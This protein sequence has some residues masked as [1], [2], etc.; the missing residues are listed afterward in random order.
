MKPLCNYLK[1]AGLTVGFLSVVMPVTAIQ[2]QDAS[3]TGS[4][5]TLEE[6][7][8]TARRREENLQNV[9]ASVQAF[10]SELLDAF[11]INDLAGITARVPG[12]NYA[13]P[14]ITDPQ[15]FMRGIGSDIQSAGADAPIGIFLNGVFMARNAGT[16]ID[17]YDLERVEVVKGPQS[18]RYGKNVVGG[19]INYVTKKPTDEFEASF[20]ATAGDYNR[21]DV[22]A[23]ARGPISEDVLFALSAVSRG[24]DPY[25]D[26]FLGDGEED[27]NRATLRG[28]LLLQVN[29]RLDITLAGDLTRLRGGS[30]W[31][32][33]AVTGDSS[34]VTYN[35]FFAP[36]I[37]GLPGF[38]LPDRN[39]PFV[40]G[41][42]RSGRKNFDGRNNA[43]M[44]DLNL[45][46]DYE[47]ASGLDLTSI[48][49]Y[50]DTETAT[51]SESCGLY[52]DFPL[53][54]ARGGLFIPD[55]TRIYG[56]SVYEYLAQ[57]PDCWF[58]QNKED[59]VSQTSQEFRL[60][61]GNTDHMEWSVGLF[62]MNE[63]I[64]RV[65]HVGFL[66]PD[67][68]VITEY[69]FSIAFGG[70]PV[71]E[72]LTQGV[73][74]AITQSDSENLG[75][76]GETTWHI[77][78]TL[79]LN[80]GLR[81]AR[82]SKKFTVTRFG[83]SFDAPIAGGGFTVSEK[84][85]WDAWLPSV[86]LSWTAAEDV[87]GYASYSRGYKPGGFFGENAG[88]PQAALVSFD[89]E[90]S[91]NFE[92]GL[93]SMLANRRVR[94]NGSVFYTDYT[95]LQTQ[96][97]V[98]IDPARPP[99]NFIANAKDGTTAY[100]LELDLEALLTENLMVFANYAYT[101]CEFNGEL[102]IDDEGTDIDG[103]TCRRTPKNGIN[104][105]ANWI[106][107]ISDNLQL[108]VGANYFWSDNFYFDNE[109]SD[110]LE[111][112]SQHSLDLRAGVSAADGKWSL[113]AWAK[114]ATDETN[115]V[116]AFE[117]FG[118]IYYNY[119]APRT[120]GVTYRHNF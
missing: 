71:G 6:V 17:L 64:S 87:S 39:R 61:G 73:S 112:P 58:N 120:Y 108:F 45:R 99:D 28:E 85:S 88:D 27:V 19:L 96:Q 119:A 42:E 46:F 32:D 49:D 65:E 36:P 75:A 55:I 11:Q 67:F 20:E 50:R 4:E 92:L 68:S 47:T 77:S 118:T 3:G 25:A 91:D 107:P 106:Q 97:F 7:T 34:A 72:D 21:I 15:I 35:R 54:P 59:N 76:F 95:D 10:S 80:A 93:K 23:S 2:A 102:I 70:E 113:T 98:Q 105:G 81:Y 84:E 110:F 103:N 89:P 60:S 79:S 22:A 1:R 37:D 33:P 115:V 13:Q 114:N 74:T 30:V 40:E 29:D 16:L 51:V 26:N 44:W 52:W 8:V 82:D 63:D 56:E 12:V 90:F 9:P 14:L 41:D 104:T 62:Y 111:I 18:L 69:A 101:R 86:T 109:N 53:I 38:V 100:G 78:D 66:F 83:D 5:L 48:T 117:L 94:L 57:V 31:I 24:H 116:N 43:D